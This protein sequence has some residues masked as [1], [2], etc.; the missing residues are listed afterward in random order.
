[1]SVLSNQ[2]LAGHPHTIDFYI[3]SN[4]T[5]AI[6]FLHGG[7]DKK[8]SFAHYLGIKE[9][10]TNADYNIS[11]SGASWLNSRQVMAVFPQGQA[12]ASNPSAWTWNNYVML[13]GTDDV[14]FLQDLVASLKADPALSGI[15]KFY[16]AGHSNGGMMANRMWCESPATFDAYGALAGP[17]SSH[18]EPSVGSNP[19]SPSVVKPYIAIVGDSDTCLRT[20]G[21]MAATYWTGNP[22]LVALMG[23]SLVDPTPLL[24]PRYMNEVLFFGTRTNLRCASAPSAPVTAGQVV[25]YSD[26]SGTLKLLVIQQTTDGSATGGDH[27]LDTLNGPCVTTL[28]GD[29]GLDPKTALHD[30]FKD[31]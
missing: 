20:T 6:I 9:T 29:T 12:I 23:D 16:L 14:A 3:P 31:F 17:P 8:E 26:C 13:S 25:T 4:A 24:Y 22:A 10:D 30:F 19:C 28:V 18:L 21:N 2:T 11:S 15:T 27:C 1:M 7:G 5:A